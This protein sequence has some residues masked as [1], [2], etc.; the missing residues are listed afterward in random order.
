MKV[1]RLLWALVPFIT[2]LSCKQKENTPAF[3]K[4]K[5]NGSK[6]FEYIDAQNSGISFSNIVSE[7]FNNNI[8]ANTYLYNRGGVG[9]LDVNND[10]LQDVFFTST[11]GTCK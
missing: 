5:F 1:Y 8:L 4:E 3:T 9:V 10:G 6:I 2:F 7:D 11:Q